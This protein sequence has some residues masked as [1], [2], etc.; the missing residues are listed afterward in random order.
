M[1]SPEPPTLAGLLASCV[2]SFLSCCFV[3]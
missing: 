3:G 1:R 2:L